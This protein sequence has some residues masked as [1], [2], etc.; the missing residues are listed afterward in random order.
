MPS[1]CNEVRDGELRFIG[2]K[3]SSGERCRVLEFGFGRPPARLSKTGTVRSIEDSNY[4]SGNKQ[5][6]A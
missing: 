1:L 4:S 3:Y 5:E 6:A 2:D